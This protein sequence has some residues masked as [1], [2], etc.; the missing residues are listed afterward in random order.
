MSREAEN[1]RRFADTRWTRDDDVGHV[2]V[3]GKDSQARHGVLI[4]H[5]FLEG[6]RNNDL[7]HLYN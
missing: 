2:A 5:N 7:N 6:D 1:G 3:A 4:A